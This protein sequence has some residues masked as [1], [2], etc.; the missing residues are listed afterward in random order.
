MIHKVAFS[1]GLQVY[2][3]RE[4]TALYRW[5]HEGLWN[6]WNNPYCVVTHGEIPREI[7]CFRIWRALDLAR[8]KIICIE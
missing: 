5:I 2:I 8:Y 6:D 4:P 7:L 3:N 1:R